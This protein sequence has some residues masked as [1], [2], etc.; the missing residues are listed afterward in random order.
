VVNNNGEFMKDIVNVSKI[1]IDLVLRVTAYERLLLKK[2]IFS[3]NELTEEITNVSN[4]LNKTM[5]EALQIEVDDEK[6]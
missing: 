5:I 6:H 3:E 1:I 2:Q 4:E